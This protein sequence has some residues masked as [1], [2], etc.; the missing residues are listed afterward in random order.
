M[1]KLICFTTNLLLNLVNMAAN[2]NNNSVFDSEPCATGEESDIESTSSDESLLSVSNKP[3]MIEFGNDM[4]VTEQF[5]MLKNHM[6]TIAN[7]NIRLNQE[8]SEIKKDLWDAWDNIYYLEKD[9]SALN[10]YTRRTSNLWYIR[11]L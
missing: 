10:R 3:M 2:N 11:R 9:L 5:D 1:I 6:N 7:M 4:T 8:V